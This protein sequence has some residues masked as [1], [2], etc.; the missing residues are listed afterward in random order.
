MDTNPELNSPTKPTPQELLGKQ[1]PPVG[2]TPSPS[3]LKS[4]Q[5]K[6]GGIFRIW[7]W[8]GDGK[9][10]RSRGNVTLDSTPTGEE[11]YSDFDDLS[12]ARGEDYNESSAR[13]RLDGLARSLVIGWTF[14]LMYIVI[15]Q[16]NKDGFGRTFWGID[17]RFIPAFNLESSEFIAVFTTTTVSVFGFLVIVANYL[18][19]KR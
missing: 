3:D 6:T 7:P 14:F 16:G 8:S 13:F 12:R 19:N 18:F 5:K 11:E 17:F 15:A 9:R 10:R 2:T 1:S 4:R